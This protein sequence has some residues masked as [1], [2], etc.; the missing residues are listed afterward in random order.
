MSRGNHIKSDYAANASKLHRLVGDIL[1]TSK[2]FSFYNICQEF[3]VNQLCPG[4]DSGHEKFDWVIPEIGVIIECMGEQHDKPV[5]FGGIP[6]D[7]AEQKFKEQVVRDLLKKQVAERGN[8]TYIT[9]WYYEKEV[10]AATLLEKIDVAGKTNEKSCAPTSEYSK[11][12]LSLTKAREYRK[13]VYNSE[14]NKEHRKT[15]KDRFNEYRRSKKDA[16][17]ASR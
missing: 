15:M 3:P 6:Q 2:F 8:W 12:G 11:H 17:K 4:F 16:A 14:K 9:V 10:T 7:E 5:C 1:R 13:Q